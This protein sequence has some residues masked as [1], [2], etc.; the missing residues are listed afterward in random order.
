MRIALLAHGYPPREPA[1]TETYTLRLAE[2][3]RARGD[4]VKVFVAAP[5]AGASPYAVEDGGALWRCAQNA[6]YGALRRGGSDPAIDALLSA[7]LTRFRPEVVYVQHL[8]NL[9]TTLRL[10][11]PY[12]WM[13]HDA[14]AWCPAGGTLLRDG[15]PCEG[16]RVL[17]DDGATCARCA[18]A[19]VRDP[20]AVTAALDLAGRVARW[21]PPARLHAAWRS[22]PPRLRDTFTRSGTA[23]VTPGHIQ[24]RDRHVRTFAGGARA[25]L[26][27]SAWLADA[28]R[29][30]GIPSP[31]VV[32]HGVDPLPLPRDPDG[33]FLF[34]GTLAP[35]KGPDLVREAHRRADVRR[36]LRIHGPPGPDA[37]YAAH[38]GADGPLDP[39]AARRALA[40]ARALVLG[41]RWPENAPLVVLE[42]RAQ[43]CPVIAPAIGGL[44]ELV[45]HGV[46][47][48]LVPPND[49]DALATAIRTLDAAP[50]EG[51]RPPRTFQHHIDE[52]RALLREV[53]IGASAV[54]P[55]TE[56]P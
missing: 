48:L 31:R 40:G 5:V 43:G 53:A 39:E 9:S 29:A 20:P 8:Q 15:V 34:L 10:P 19:W 3:L 11:A 49:V 28:A 37:G 47:G 30:E 35:H 36:P 4:E 17:A 32:P 27:P 12:V 55:S 1:G 2:A 23:S 21:I 50:L 41:S 24:Q 6:P 38:L 18:S 42:A 54:T 51:V 26:S 45:A 22:L 16:P 52:V 33:P 14:W 25:L 7:A 13:L 56:A 44:P 46:D